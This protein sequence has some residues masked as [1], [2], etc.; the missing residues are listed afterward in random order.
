MSVANL[1]KLGVC[2]RYPYAYVLRTATLVEAE[3]K[4]GVF[5]GAVGNFGMNHGEDDK[6]AVFSDPPSWLKLLVPIPWLCPL[7]NYRGYRRIVPIIG[8]L[9]FVIGVFSQLVLILVLSG[10][11]ARQNSR[12]QKIWTFNAGQS[13]VAQRIWM[14]GWLLANMYSGPLVHFVAS[15]G[16][17]WEGPWRR[18]ISYMFVFLAYALA[19]GGFVTVG[20][21]LDAENSYQ[22][23]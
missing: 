21:M 1:T 13:T 11:K 16:R 7:G 8:G 15:S 22:L 10:V 6:V 23:C 5:S 17:G 14:L 18:W 19:F 3:G 20:R 9:F 2:G 4:G 12:G